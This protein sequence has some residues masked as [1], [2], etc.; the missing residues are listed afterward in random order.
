MLFGRIPFEH[1]SSLCGA[2]LSKVK[3]VTH[4]NQVKQMIQVNEVK[5]AIQG[6]RVKQGNQVNQVKQVK[7]KPSLCIIT[8]QGHISKVSANSQ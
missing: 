2:S 4:V 5:Q 6:K 1:A 7:V 3:Q 8:H